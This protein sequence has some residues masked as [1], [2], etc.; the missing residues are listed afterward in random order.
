MN[1]HFYPVEVENPGKKPEPNKK[2]KIPNPKTKWIAVIILAVILL[3]PATA[4]VVNKIMHP[5]II[6]VLVEP[7]L[8]YEWISPCG[9]GLLTAQKNGYCGLI[10]KYGNIAVPLIYTHIGEFN[11]GLAVA[12]KGR[13]R[14][15]GGPCGAIDKNGNIVIDFIYEGMGAFQNGLAV[16]YSE[17]KFGVI[18]QSGEFVIPLIYGEISGFLDGFAQVRK[19]DK[20]GILDNT[21]EIVIPFEYDNIVR[22]IGHGFFAT[23]HHESLNYLLNT[24]GEIVLPTKYEWLGYYDWIGY[25]YDGMAAVSWDG[26]CGYIDNT[27]EVAIYPGY[28]Y[29]VNDFSDGMASICVPADPRETG[30]ISFRS[31]YGKW[32]F[33]DKTGELV[34]PAEYDVAWEFFGG[35]ARVGI[36]GEDENRTKWGFIN[37]TGEIVVP[38]I[39]EYLEPF[40]NG[41]AVGIRE[42]ENESLNSLQVIDTSGNT[43]VSVSAENVTI[44]DNGRIIL[45]RQNGKEGLMNMKGEVILPFEYDN[46]YINNTRDNLL[47]VEKDGLWGILETG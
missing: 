34:I 47:C 40:V 9:E 31:Y 45:V 2:K 32:G 38:L 4:Y 43:I 20:W 6:K 21:G 19:D 14:G 29:S 30:S 17:G 13:A 25:F 26:L 15:Y 16:A 33:I 7:R 24:K 39:Y 23:T 44:S 36:C 22:N 18:N 37:K 28:P 42:P 41:L 11:D 27:G 1:G 3:S 8:D 5:E 35:F 12:F 46:I 10:D